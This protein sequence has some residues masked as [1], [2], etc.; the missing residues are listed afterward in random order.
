VVLHSDSATTEAPV[1][2][3][4]IA[5]ATKVLEGSDNVTQVVPPRPGVSI[6][7]A[8]HTAIV[9]AGAA[10]DSNEMVRAA[11]DVKEELEAISGEEMSVY[12]T[13]ASGMW[14]D[15]N[16]ANLAAM[17]KSELMSWPVT[18]LILVLA[19]GSL[20]AAGLPL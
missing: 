17:L 16:E 18:M 20:V 12:L 4:A 6:S 2:R 10:G 9:Q 7:R 1:Y 8:G 14:S 13:G 15:F 11:D 5:E 3:A 19:F